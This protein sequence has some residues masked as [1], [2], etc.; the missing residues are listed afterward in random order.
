MERFLITGGS[1]FLGKRLG[2]RLREL[3]HEVVLAA[4]NNKQ[5]FLASEFSG[6]R[7]IAMDVTSIESVRDIFTQVKPT[8]VVHAAATKFVDISERQPMETIDV[9][10]LGS[11]NVAR[12]AIDKGVKLVIGISTDKASPPVRNTYGMT[13][14]LMERVYCSMDDKSSTRFVCVR[15]GNVAWSTASVL[16]AWRKDLKRTG[17]I[18]T[19]GP[20]MFRYFFTCDEAVELV[21][22]A[23]ENAK[24]LYGKVLSRKMKAAMMEDILRVWTQQEKATYKKI[25]GRPGE[26]LQEFL[27]GETELPYTVERTYNGITHYIISFNERA[28]KPL[29]A[30]LGSDTAE[31]LTD[32]EIATLINNPPKEEL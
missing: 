1:G 27:I 30:V 3:G 32:A 28:E 10:I 22:T 24:D 13:K 8:V 11:Q 20:E 5:N 31:R 15:Y 16:T 2:K 4:R 25:T 19:T 9:N 12:V 7:N 29:P 6:C 18:E 26:R 14:A 21:C 17:V 23:Y